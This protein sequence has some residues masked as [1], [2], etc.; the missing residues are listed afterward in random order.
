[1]YVDIL[2]NIQ[3][4]R[5]KMKSIRKTLEMLG[6]QEK[7]TTY[8]GQCVEINKVNTEY[9]FMTCIKMNFS[10]GLYETSNI[11]SNLL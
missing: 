5:K 11:I 10:S 8:T 7:K 1:M 2:D 9:S 3:Q 4:A 6:K